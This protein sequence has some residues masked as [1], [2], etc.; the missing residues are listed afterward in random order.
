MDPAQAKE[1][2]EKMKDGR[3]TPEEELSLLVFLNQG[4]S[5]LREFIKE[6]MTGTGKPA[7]E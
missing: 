2:A 6:T 5:T 3:A 4:V 1:L 7:S